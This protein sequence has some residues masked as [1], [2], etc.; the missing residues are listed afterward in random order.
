MAR[1]LTTDRLGRKRSYGLSLRQNQIRT[2]FSNGILKTTTPRAKEVRSMVQSLLSDMSAKEITLAKKRKFKTILGK[3]EL[4]EKAIKYAQN[5]DY[6]VRIIKVGYRSGDN[7]QLSRVELIG[8]EGKRKR[9][10]G[11]EKEEKVEKQTTAKESKKGRKPNED[12]AK[13]EPQKSASG[14]VS[15]AQRKSTER[16]RTRAGL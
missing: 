10:T 9:K 5:E 2:L 13:R 4:V 14:K 11:L 1:K 6:G 16:V 3:K 8:F 15:K 12:I 7:A